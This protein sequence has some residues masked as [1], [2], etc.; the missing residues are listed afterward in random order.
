VEVPA[1]REREG[2]DQ[3][4]HRHRTAERDEGDQPDDVLRREHLRERE[5]AR[6]RR[7]EDD[8]R[9]PAPPEQDGRGDERGRHRE[10]GAAGG[11]RV[12][13]APGKVT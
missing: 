2:G 1:L 8:S 10:H 3:E 12:R 6:H 9:P 11:D 5:E 7:S 4:E 13:Q